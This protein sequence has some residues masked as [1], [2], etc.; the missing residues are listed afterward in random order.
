MKTTLHLSGRWDADVIPAGEGAQRGLLLEVVAQKPRT[1]SDRKPVNLCLVLDRSGS[2]QGGKLRA[3]R[4]AAIDVVSRLLPGDRLSVVAF[5]DE[6]E[7]LFAG[8][9]MDESG[10]AEAIT[11]IGGLNA[12]AC[13]DLAGGWF[14]GARCVSSLMESATD[15]SSG[16]VVLLSDGMANRGITDPRQLQKHA[17]ELA[18][19]GVTSSCVGVGNGYSPLQLDAIAEGGGGRLHDAET[20]EEMAAVIL[21]E[22]GEV[23][24]AAAR[25]A[26][27]DI[28]WP[29]GLRCTVVANYPV[30]QNGSGVRVRLGN[31]TAN[32]PRTIP[33]VVESSPDLAIGQTSSVEVSFTAAE[34]SGEPSLPAASG[35]FVLKAVSAREAEEAPL[36]QSVVQRI[37]GMWSASVSYQA[38]RLNEAHDYHGAGHRVRQYGQAIRQYVAGTQAEAAINLQLDRAESRVSS[39]WDTRSK[40]EAMVRAKKYGRSERDYRAAKP[41]DLWSDELDK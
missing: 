36:D 2:M 10:K 17:S 3:A 18:Q 9:S 39:A 11:A 21:E 23:L 26:V 34:A 13:T 32:A 35:E 37:S 7:T 38:M 31:L 25:N 5:D 16:H 41:A 22:L 6:I 40:R 8:L 4:Q 20:P 12:R 28:S 24:E 27:V 14:E 33:V 29:A 1:D 19:R 15:F 30:V